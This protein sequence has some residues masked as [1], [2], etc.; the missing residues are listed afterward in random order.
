MFV[1][2]DGTKFDI[3]N[4]NESKSIKSESDVHASV[5]TVCYNH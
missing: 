1:N 2:T 4:K 5:K 3:I